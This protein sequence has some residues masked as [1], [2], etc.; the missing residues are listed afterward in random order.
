MSEKLIVENCIIHKSKNY[1]Y[2]EIEHFEHI[3]S[4]VDVVSELIDKGYK[5]VTASEYIVYLSK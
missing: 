4:L 5:V 2:V 1:V 3:L